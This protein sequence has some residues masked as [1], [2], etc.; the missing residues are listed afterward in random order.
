MAYSLCTEIIT[1]NDQIK[2]Y[3]E[4]IKE[5]KCQ[6]SDRIAKLTE[7]MVQQGVEVYEYEG[8][9]FQL[10]E[11]LQR[12]PPSFEEKIEQIKNKLGDRSIRIDSTTA[13]Q[14]LRFD[15]AAEEVKHKIRIK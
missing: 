9:K 8:H 10:K 1:L 15:P 12:I 11:M 3:S 13:A 6:R 2:S 4:K 14:L 5:L 7:L